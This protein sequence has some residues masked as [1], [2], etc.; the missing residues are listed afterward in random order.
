MNPHQHCNV[1]CLHC[2][3]LLLHT[4]HCKHT[5][6]IV[7]YIINY[8]LSAEHRIL[9]IPK[10][11]LLTAQCTVDHAH[12]TIQSSIFKRP[13]AKCP[14]QN[15]HCKMH[16][17]KFTLPPEHFTHCP[18]HHVNLALHIEHYTLDH[19]HYKTGH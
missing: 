17:A 6:H 12:C 15:A 10:Y 16:T 8:A 9:Y 1:N 19:V 14:L 18:L 3:Q 4:A 11:T 5:L 2:T 7:V 13:T